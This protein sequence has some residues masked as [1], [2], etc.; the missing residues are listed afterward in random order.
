[1]VLSF[2]S[3]SRLGQHLAEDGGVGA[4]GDAVHAAGAVL[5]DVDRDLRGDVAEVAEGGGAGGDQRAG[6]RQVGRQLLFAVAFLVAADDALVEVDH[7]EHRQIDEL[8]GRIDQRAV[9][10]VVERIGS[11][12]SFIEGL[13]SGLGHRPLLIKFRASNRN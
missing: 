8:V 5:G 12:A 10:V 2:A 3:S 1:M 9:A 4:L 13:L 6:Q 7:V 11:W